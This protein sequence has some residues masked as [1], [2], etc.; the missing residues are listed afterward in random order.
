MFF[1]SFFPRVHWVF[2][3]NSRK[4]LIVGVFTV[5]FGSVFIKKSNQ[6][7]FFFLKKPKPN[8]NR[9]KPNGFGSVRFGFLEKKPVQTGLARFFQFDSVWLGFFR[10]GSVF[11]VWLGFDSVWLGFFS[12]FFSIRFGSVFPVPGLK[13]RNRTEPVGFF[14]ILIGLIDFFSRFGFFGYFFPGFLGLI[15]FSVFLNTPS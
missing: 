2:L 13:N 3:I 11:S 7:E 5:R 12:G 14:K 8:W 6:T 10:F 4:L 15:G 9:F 1:L